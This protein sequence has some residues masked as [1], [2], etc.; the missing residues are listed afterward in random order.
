MSEARD[1][2]IA[3]I[4]IRASSSGIDQWVVMPIIGADGVSVLAIAAGTSKLFDPRM[5]IGRNGL[6]CKLS[7]DPIRLLR[8]GDAHAAAESGESRRKSSDAAADNRYITIELL[9]VRSESRQRGQG[10]RAL[11]Q[12]APRQ[13]QNRT[14]NPS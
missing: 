8:Q 2:T 13:S 10:N 1:R 9:G 4:Q 5:L 7:S 11:K 6:R 3:R 12:T 14:F